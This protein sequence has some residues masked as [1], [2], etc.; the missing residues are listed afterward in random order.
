MG[1]ISISGEQLPE[2]YALFAEIEPAGASL[3]D[4]SVLH[5]AL[6]HD[7]LLLT[8]DKALRTQSEVRMVEC[9]GTF[10]IL[11][12]LVDEGLLLPQ[13]AAD[14]LVY[15]LGLTGRRKRFLPR[16]LAESYIQKWRK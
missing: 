5:I 4:A 9:H 12:Q 1:A 16:A 3:E 6:A 14:K 8:G 7:A 10:W 11:E 13:I 2:L 15:L